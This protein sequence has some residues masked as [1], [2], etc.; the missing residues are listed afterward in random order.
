MCLCV[1]K[2]SDIF[3]LIVHEIER[4]QSMSDDA[5]KGGCVVS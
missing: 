1:Q 3:S 2:V 5:Q 4:S